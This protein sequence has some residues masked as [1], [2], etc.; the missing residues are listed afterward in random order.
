MKVF[1]AA[2][3]PCKKLGLVTKGLRAKLRRRPLAANVHRA[4]DWDTLVVAGPHEFD[5]RRGVWFEYSAPGV[6]AA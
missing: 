3:R 2:A 5:L 4:A 1:A 6:V